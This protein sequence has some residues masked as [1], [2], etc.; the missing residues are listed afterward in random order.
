MSPR[1]R[2]SRQ[3][4]QERTRG[5]LLDTAA[6]EFLR[7]GYHGT[8]LDRVAELAGYSK[9]A[10]YSNFES[11]EELCLAVLDR[12]YGEQFV[13]LSNELAVAERTP[14]ARIAAVQPWWEKLASEQDWRLLETE[15]ILQ[16]RFSKRLRSTLVR[17]QRSARNFVAQ[18]LEEQREELGLTLPFSP[19]HLAVALLGLGAAIATQRVFEPDLPPEILTETIGALLNRPS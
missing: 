9:G 18:L 14:E 6:K 10:V 11:K 8:S 7:R 4:S 16:A 3:E 5:R 12:H 17:R 15:V 13:A 19:D 1:R 2:L